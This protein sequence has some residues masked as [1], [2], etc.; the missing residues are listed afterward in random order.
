MKVR[1]LGTGRTLEVPT[2]MVMT[3][4]VVKGSV[5]TPLAYAIEPSAAMRF[6]PVLE[7]QGL[8]FET[9]ASPRRAKVER[10]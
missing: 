2:A 5:P 7:A 3:D 9:L 10:V 1:E 4:L 6:L 8:R